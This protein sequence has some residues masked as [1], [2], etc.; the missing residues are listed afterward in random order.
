MA[1]TKR[2]RRFEFLRKNFTKMMQK[3]LV[4]LFIL[5]I[6]AFLGLVMRITYIN[7]ADGDKYTKLVLDQQQYDS[8]IIPFKRGD[9]LDRNGTKIATSERVYNVILDA[10]VLLSDKK[11]VEP[12]KEVLAECF[13][14]PE[15]DVDKVLEERPDS[16]YIILKKRVSYETAQ[17][18][19]AIDADNETY[20][21]VNGVW[22]EEDYVR[23]YPYD[24]L[25]CDV[26]GFTS[27]GNVGNGGIEGEYNEI[28]NG[29]DGRE[30]GYLDSDSSLERVVKE[31]QN[32]Q[33][34]VT[35]IDLNLQS[36]IESRIAEFNRRYE[37]YD[38]NGRRIQLGSKNTAV[39]VMNPNTGEVLAEAC[40]PFFNLNDPRDL[41]QFYTDQEIIEL[42]NT[43]DEK[44]GLKKNILAMQ[45]IWR[46][47]CVSDTY[48]PGSTAK[49]FTVAAGLESGKM[50]G[51]EQYVCG[52]S[53]Q[54]VAGDR[55]IKCHN[56]SGHGTETVEGAI[57]DSCNVALMHMVEKIGA[58]EFCKYQSI[59]GFGEYTGIDLPGEASGILHDPENIGIVDLATNS[60]GQNFNI[61]MTQMA[62]A[63]SSLVNGG[64]YYRPYIV[65]QIRDDSGN[66]IE[67]KD[68]VLLK[69][70]I[71]EKTYE[72][73]KTYL[74]AV[75]DYGT[76]KPCQVEG[77]HIGGKTGT[78]EKYPR[79]EGKHLLSFI[80][81]APLEK[82]E[83]VV[84]VVLDELNVDDQATSSYVL[85]LSRQIME[86]IFPYLN[87]TKMDEMG[88]AQPAAG[89]TAGADETEAPGN[90][91][92]ASDAEDDEGSGSEDS[93]NQE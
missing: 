70:T 88:A 80:G 73:L 91:E 69:R 79:G 82:P 86:D 3:K 41:T 14:I 32:G 17:K 26:V 29:T 8:R 7:A 62:A 38:D 31:A 21:D 68:P 50:D 25:A 85:E 56:L 34:V 30:Y 90:E 75:L 66:I 28:L 40:Y 63:F 35:T 15:A 57:A 54:V 65:K 61:T 60:F 19:E 71:S 87:V 43:T 37:K 49:P 13:E 9:I 46:N 36:M 5:V 44:T 47:F 11:D 2:K 52:G 16:R 78:A 24:S 39:M 83:V 53:L 84:Y 23:K 18:F 22:L 64:N 59:F 33:N 12:T 51:N 55:P 72:M 45:D 67:N 48:E 58:E 77:Y 76:G 27:S 42:E 89:D 81:C 4:M 20:P 6:L 74:G 10:K 92:G 1:K 93:E